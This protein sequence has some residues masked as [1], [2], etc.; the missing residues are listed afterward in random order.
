[1][2]RIT[3]L[4][5]PLAVAAGI[6]VPTGAHATDT[7]A[8]TFAVPCA[9]PAG[10]TTPAGIGLP[11]GVYAVTVSGACA[12][13]FGLR[14]VPVGGTPCTAPV[15]GPVPC[16]SPVTTINNAPT[17]GQV[18]TGSGDDITTAPSVSLP[19]CG[20]LYITIDG[21][22]FAGQAGTYNRTI[23]GPMTV[24]FV[25]TYYPDNVGELIVTV[26]WTPL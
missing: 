14:S 22:C 11:T 4:L 6:A 8:W 25:D 10:A 13:D 15:V 9:S 3:R 19:G 24:A 5:L 26:T 18:S 23:S 12:V 20:L 7:L 21:N 17:F 2:R 1:M 16:T